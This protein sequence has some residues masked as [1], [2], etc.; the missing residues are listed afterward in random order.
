MRDRKRM[1]LERRESAQK[2]QGEVE[3]EETTIRKHSNRKETIFKIVQKCKTGKKK[4]VY[5]NKLCIEEIIVHAYWNIN[6]LNRKV[7]IS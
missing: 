4:P 7:C 1:Y 2:E 5:E 3:G 6:I